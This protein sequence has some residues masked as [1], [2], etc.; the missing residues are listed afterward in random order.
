M[1]LLASPCMAEMLDLSA[2]GDIEE[3]QAYE[4]A[5]PQKE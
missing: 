3:A 1:T 4:E 2:L 5:A